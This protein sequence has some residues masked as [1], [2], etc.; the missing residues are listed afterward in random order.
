MS[1]QFY[2]HTVLMVVIV[3][4]AVLLNT[5]LRGFPKPTMQTL[6]NGAWSAQ[7]E[8][9]LEEKIGFHDSLFRLKSQIDLLIGE[10]LIQD[11]YITDDMLLEKLGSEPTVSTADSVN[12]LNQFYEKYRIP[13]YLILVPSAS[14]IYEDLLPANAVKENQQKQISEIYT[15]VM[16][17]IRYVDAYNILSSLKEEYVYYRTDTHWTSYGAYAVY[18]SAIRKM[19]FTAVP[20]NRYV[21]SHLSTDFRGDLYERTLYDDV[22]ADVLDCYTYEN[23]GK[24]VS[25][26]AYYADGTEEDRGTQLYAHSRLESGNMY[27][28]YLGRPC[29]MLKIRTDLENDKRLLIYKDDFANCM[30][31][32]L[33]QHYSEI[34]IVDLEQ[35][36]GISDRLANPE[37]F[38]QVLFLSS[39][40][41]WENVWMHI[42]QTE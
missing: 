42:G 19:G 9:F 22:K 6:V 31:P 29:A 30:I 25:V 5:G 26:T 41:S 3:Y 27:E 2:Y 16:T 39:M 38:T 37:E 20:Y 10:R 11:V 17:G 32:F 23:G 18:Q 33:L 35:S 40:E 12:V 7:V 1:K 4:A 34:C 21:V 15:G 13:T 8:S 36:I 28:F 24:A 14:E